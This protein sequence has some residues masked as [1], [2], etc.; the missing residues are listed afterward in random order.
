MCLG[1]EDPELNHPQ[2]FAV[3]P[4]RLVRM[5]AISL[6]APIVGAL[7]VVVA[8]RV[9]LAAVIAATHRRHGEREQTSESKYSKH[10]NLPVH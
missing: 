3:C 6:D 10:G 7:I 2:L 4:V 9:V 5:R 8:V 1:P